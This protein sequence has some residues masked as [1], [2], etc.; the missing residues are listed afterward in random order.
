MGRICKKVGQ[1]VD[2]KETKK[3]PRN[4]VKIRI[5]N[6]VRSDYYFWGD[7]PVFSRHHPVCLFQHLRPT[8]VTSGLL[9]SSE[10]VLFMEMEPTSQ[11]ISVYFSSLLSAFLDGHSTSFFV[12]R[13]IPQLSLP[14]KQRTNVSCQSNMPTK[15]KPLVNVHA[16]AWRSGTHKCTPSALPTRS[17]YSEMLNLWNPWTNA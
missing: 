4:I 9:T 16:K 8:E 7:H 15:P 17:N 13:L 6:V 5:F 3:H 12:N 10:H 14:S 1:K 2:K 11:W